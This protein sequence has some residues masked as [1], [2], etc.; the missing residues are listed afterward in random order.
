MYMYI[1]GTDTTDGKYIMYINNNI[2]IKQVTMYIILYV[3]LLSTLSKS[4]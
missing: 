4:V 1:L 3:L 2:G